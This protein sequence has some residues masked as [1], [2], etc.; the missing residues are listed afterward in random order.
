MFDVA[1]E[2]ALIPLAEREAKVREVALG[3]API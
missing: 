3:A 1:R 2:I